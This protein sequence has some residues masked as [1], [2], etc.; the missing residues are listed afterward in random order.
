MTDKPKTMHCQ[1]CK[2][3]RKVIYKMGGI[4]CERCRIVVAYDTAGQPIVPITI[5]QTKRGNE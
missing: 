5:T 1:R 4:I 3:E 2:C